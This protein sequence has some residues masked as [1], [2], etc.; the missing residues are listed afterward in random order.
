MQEPHKPVMTDRVLDYLDIGDNIRVVDGTLGAGGHAE[1]LLKNNPGITLLGIDRDKE[2]LKTAEKRLGEFGERVIVRQ[3]LFG[4]LEDIVENLEWEGVH[5]VLLDLGMSSMQLDSVDRGFS[6]KN[7]APLDMRM[8]RNAS[9]TAASL[10]NTASEKRLA[11]IFFEYGEERKSRRLARAVVERREQ[12]K[13][14]RT[15]EFTDLVE[16]VVGYQGRGKLPPPTRTF[17][18]LRI[19]VNEELDQL[20]QGLKA[21]VNVLFP[22]GRLVVISYHSL[23][24]RMVKR[25]F[26]H[27]AA[28]CVCPPGMPECRCNKIVRLK[29]LTRKPIRPD[30]GEVE[31]NSRS[32]PARLRVAEKV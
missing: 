13:W 2:A 31:D 9:V 3:G 29:N 10:L 17:Q 30:A 26:K 16:K 32:K 22:G 21:A 5:G 27:E 12:K 23:E 28:S 1:R 19:A 7:D 18:A 25:H 14:E 8:N 11:D 24:D 15:G 4:E 20:K 6:Y